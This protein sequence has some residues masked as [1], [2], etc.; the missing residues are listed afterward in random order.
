MLFSINCPSWQPYF[1]ELKPIIRS[2]STIEVDKRSCQSYLK[3]GKHYAS[4]QMSE[5]K[6][7]AFRATKILSTVGVDIPVDCSFQSYQNPVNS[8]SLNSRQR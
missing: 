7:I 1:L 8:G 2:K 5:L 6:T 3:N 4:Y